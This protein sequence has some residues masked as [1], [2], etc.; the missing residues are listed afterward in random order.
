M[1]KCT[2]LLSRKTSL[3]VVS[4][5]C[6]SN[7]TF[8]RGCKNQMLTVMRELSTD[9][10]AVILGIETSCDD[11]G[12]GIVDTTGKILGEALNSQHLTHLR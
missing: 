7:L 3:D 12:C 11:T 4:S 2:Y 6:Q 10:P 8:L 5:L 1:A 9:R